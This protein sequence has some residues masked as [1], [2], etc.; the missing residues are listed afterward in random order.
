MTA[1]AP[2]LSRPYRAL[3]NCPVC[4][5]GAGDTVFAAERVPVL[6]NV[7][8]ATAAEALDAETGSVDLV[9]CHSCG[10]LWNAAFDEAAIEYSPAYENSLHFSPRFQEFATGLAADLVRR[11]G[12][13]G[14]TV[15]EV[16]SGK[17][18]FLALLCDAGAARGIG[19]DP[20][21]A[22]D[23]PERVDLR[24]TASLFPEEDFPDADFVCAR[25][26]FEH[27][28]APA[29]VLANIRAAIPPHRPVGFYIEVPDGTYLLS[30]VAL[31]DV[32]YEHPLHFT[33][34]A[35]ER[36]FAGAGLGVTRIATSFGDQYL[37][38]EGSTV[39]GDGRNPPPGGDGLAG[40]AGLA[41]TF[42][43][44]AA[45]LRGRW[46]ARLAH[47]CERGP[48]VLW[49]AGSKGVSFLATVP[50]AGEIA[51][52]VDINPRKRGR[53]VPM[54]GHRVVAPGDL[55]TIRPVAVVLLNPI[56]RAEVAATLDT[57]GIR[58]ALVTD[59]AG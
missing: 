8:F 38:V 22:G 57:V 7:L 35:M 6:C 44:R 25:H 58:T 43:G 4:G 18:D 15:L 50:G 10:L 23:T 31:W 27:L 2:G 34:P 26:V 11:N 59:P 48:V 20:T 16:G 55:A 56:Y 29:R 5:E 28:C 21:Y 51:A 52:I 37:S 24:F 45:D 17:G 42:G 3:A 53:Y 14:R 19:Y 54:T 46:S 40:L 1:A 33:A 49:G 32:I 30:E 13:A 41:A 47:L 39:V 9:L 12:L 36:L